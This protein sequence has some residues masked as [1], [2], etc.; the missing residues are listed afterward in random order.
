MTYN[1]VLLVV[2]AATI[3][4]G[5]GPVLTPIISSCHTVNGRFDGWG[6]Y[7]RIPSSGSNGI[8]M[9][10]NS[11][12]YYVNQYAYP[13]A[14]ENFYQLPP[15]LGKNVSF[16]VDVSS[17]GCGRILAVYLAQLPSGNP[18]NGYY[19][20][21]NSI[22]NLCPEIDLLEANRYA[23]HLAT[24]ACNSSEDDGDDEKRSPGRPRPTYDWCN[25]WGCTI[26]I[27][28]DQLY[29]EG[30]WNLINTR[31]P[32]SVNVG[33]KASKSNKLEAVGVVLS[34]KI[35]AI[36]KSI[37]MAIGATCTYVAPYPH[38]ANPDPPSSDNKL[39]TP[40]LPSTIEFSQLTRVLKGTMA[41]VVSNWYREN[42]CNW[43]DPQCAIDKT[44]LDKGCI[45]YGDNTNALNT[46]EP[47]GAVNN[48]VF[49]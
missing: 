7:S 32:Y 4:S 33:F 39:H 37:S 18:L 47:I 25:M 15:L 27:G 2:A 14:P 23:F 28:S 22:G 36:E 20:D 40:T 45:D 42:T 19:C 11:R 9:W 38:M 46:P 48:L 13:M 24:H 6:W 12:A 49:G 43:L 17:F 10:P 26:N 16:D 5:A 44:D 29:G 34:Q 30:D 41:L 21:A 1:I 8:Q 3:A 35:G 31:Y